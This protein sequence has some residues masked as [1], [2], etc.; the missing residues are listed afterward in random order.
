MTLTFHAKTVTW[1]VL[2]S[3]LLGGGLYLAETGYRALAFAKGQRVAVD[4]AQSAL[5]LGRERADTY[6]ALIDRIGWRPGQALRHETIDTSATISGG[7]ADRLNDI[8]QAN[9]VG[10]GQFF[11]RSLKLETTRPSGS[12]EP[13]LKVSIKGDNILVLDRP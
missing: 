2:S 6:A 3:S 12:T 9:H 7:E 5:S 13:M 8:L 1:L 11:L 10:R 4:K